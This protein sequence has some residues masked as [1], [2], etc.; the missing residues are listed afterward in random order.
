MLSYQKRT[1][2]FFGRKTFGRKTLGRKTLGRKTLGRKTLGR[3]TLGRKT[4]G[5]KTL[6]R[7]TLGTRYIAGCYTSPASK[8]EN[9]MDFHYFICQY[10]KMRQQ[11]RKQPQYSLGPHPLGSFYEINFPRLKVTYLTYYPTDLQ[12]TEKF[13]AWFRN[14]VWT[15]RSLDNPESDMVGVYYT[16][17]RQA[18]EK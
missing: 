5:R 11:Y 16:F 10:H 14:F 17:D 12:E 8:Y 18:R 13:W 3:K 6:G 15:W 2:P 1:E 4:L 7:K 9:N